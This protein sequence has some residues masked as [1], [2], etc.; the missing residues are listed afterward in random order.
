MCTE[1]EV[2]YVNNNLRTRGNENWPIRNLF[3]GLTFFNAISWMNQ[4][5]LA[6]HLEG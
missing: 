3:L 1:Y 6:E 2:M 4:F 5:Y